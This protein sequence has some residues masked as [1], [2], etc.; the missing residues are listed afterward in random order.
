[1]RAATA[2]W[3]VL[4]ALVGCNG[5]TGV[6]DLE[7]VDCLDCVDATPL[8]T[9]P[10]DSVVV[11]TSAPPDT[12]EADTLAT[13]ADNDAMST[14][15]TEEECFDGSA[16]TTDRCE[17]TGVCSNTLVDRDGDG[18]AATALGT[19]GRDCND[20]DETVVSTQTMFF[21]TAYALP[22]GAKS[23]D[24][25]CDGRSEQQSITPFK[26]TYTGSTC[27]L[28]TPG[29]VGTVPGCGATGKWS[30]GCNR[31]SFGTFCIPIQIDRLQTCR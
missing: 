25:N 5:L 14:C 15:T 27:V 12:A 9:S 30:A 17:P 1:M 8:D 2:I 28:T 13:D 11:E 23:F 22:S 6:N 21:A 26:C 29:W 4:P 3:W 31:S 20:A 18:E 16:C 24:Y 19:C 10:A 7:P